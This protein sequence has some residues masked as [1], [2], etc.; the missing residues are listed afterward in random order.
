LILQ[1]I[2]IIAQ[3]NAWAGLALN[4]LDFNCFYNPSIQVLQLIGNSEEVKV[5]L[6]DLQGRLI[7]TVVSYNLKGQSSINT[8]D[9]RKQ[10]YV[11]K[12]TDRFKGEYSR[13]LVIY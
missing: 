2:I 8:S 3:G 10:T 1:Y 5:E 13:R 7:K 9:L 6:F 4:E 11:V 12:V